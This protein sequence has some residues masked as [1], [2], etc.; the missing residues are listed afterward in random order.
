M[1]RK[2]DLA[3]LTLEGNGI[4]FVDTR[5]AYLLSGEL[6]EGLLIVLMI[7][8]RV[9]MKSTSHIG[10]DAMMKVQTIFGRDGIAK[11]NL[12]HERWQSHLV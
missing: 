11:Q 5:E 9:V 4:I 1:R 2:I 6:V 12:D 10:R 7:V 8:G 3:Q